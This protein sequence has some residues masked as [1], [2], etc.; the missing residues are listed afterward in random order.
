MSEIDSV[1]D[2]STALPSQERKLQ[3]PTELLVL[4]AFNCQ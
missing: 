1:Q 2:E 3:V 4:M